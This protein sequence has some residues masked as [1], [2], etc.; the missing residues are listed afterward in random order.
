MTLAALRSRGA[1]RS[2]ASKPI[3]LAA[4]ALLLGGL[5][6]GG[7]RLAFVGTAWL[8]DYPLI[9]S[10]APAVL[11][12]SLEALFLVLMAT[13][14][15]SVLIASIGILYGGEDLELL[16]AQPVSNSA[17]FGLKTFELFLNTAGLPLLLTTP[18]LLGVG[19]AVGAH[20]LYYPVGLLAAACV[21][22]LPVTLGALLALVLVRISPT[23]KVKEVATA[24]SVTAAAG[25]VFGFRLLR[26]E[27]LA[28]LGTMSPEEF[29]AALTAF[30]RFEIGWL[31]PAWATSAS[32]AAIDGRLHPG[33]LVLVLLAGSG[34]L[35]TGFLARYAFS[36]GWV[37]S[38]DSTP[39]AGAAKRRAGEPWWEVQLRRRLGNIGLILAT[40]L[41]TF[42]RDVQQWSQVMVLVALG[43]VY[44]FSL[45]SIPVPNQQFRD[46]IGAMNLA[47]IGFLLAG[48]A[49]RI[50]FPSV[51]YE[52]AAFWLTQI[53]PIRKRD[54]VLARFLLILPMMLGLGLSVGIAARIALDLSPILAFAAPVA[55]AA[56]AVALTG[57]AVGMGACFPKFDFTNPNELVMTPGAIAYM[58]LAMTHS[59]LAALLFARPAWLS[60]SGAGGGEMG[61]YWSKPEGLVILALLLFLTLVAGLLPLILGARQLS[62]IEL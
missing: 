18:V 46:A 4:A 5:L 9:G 34:L 40:G 20:A 43:A 53:S 48:V 12:R 51:S 6:F 15:F 55:G 36:H 58:A 62:R 33:L 21:Y 8:L 35:L 50:A 3:W 39:A 26:P 47:F 16:L 57:L 31:P 61:G 54:L 7:Y 59:A 38:L 25:A 45:A 49:L 14:L 22:A 24:V 56:N 10:I 32:W 42:Y 2:L 37:R 1:V 60:L 29:E 17:V 11:Q 19:R 30:T 23:G 41:R 27:Q 28:S 44:L 52:G 13:V